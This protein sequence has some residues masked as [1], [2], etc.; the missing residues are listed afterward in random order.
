MESLRQK[1][2]PVLEKK[3]G[4]TQTFYLVLFREDELFDRLLNC[5][6]FRKAEAAERAVEDTPDASQQKA[7][8]DREEWYGPGRFILYMLPFLLCYSAYGFLMGWHVAPRHAL[9]LAV[10][11]LFVA[12]STPL[13]GFLP[14]LFLTRRYCESRLSLRERAGQLGTL[15]AGQMAVSGVSLF[16]FLPFLGLMLL[17]HPPRPVFQLGNVV[18]IGVA[19][20]LG[21]LFLVRGF[22]HIY[23]ANLLSW[24]IGFGVV[25]YLI[26]ALEWASV[27]GPYFHLDEAFAQVRLPHELGEVLCPRFHADSIAQPLPSLF[28]ET[29]RLVRHWLN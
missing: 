5:R 1:F 14:L 20:V 25:L 12:V 13:L 23:K 10:R 18:L 26:V 28:R 4:P 24:S 9:Y 16:A 21:L 6:S 17:R 15:L 22:S 3:D 27:W 7:K 19:G 29:V 2:K 8:D 11:L